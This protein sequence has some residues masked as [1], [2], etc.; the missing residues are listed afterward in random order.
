MKFENDEKVCYNNKDVTV[1]AGTTLNRKVGET[2]MEEY[3]IYYKRNLIGILVRDTKKKKHR[4]T[5][6]KEISPNVREQLKMFPEL[7]ENSQEWS[8]PI[9]VLENRIRDARRFGQ[10]K[11]IANQTD[12]FRI[13]K[14][15][16][17]HKYN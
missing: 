6:E 12:G 11:N 1:E 17:G 16:L 13:K 2:T 10:I 14:I 9:P 4:Y 5:P 8:E 7:L 15:R 3:K